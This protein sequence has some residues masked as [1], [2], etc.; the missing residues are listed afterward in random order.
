MKRDVVLEGLAYMARVVNQVSSISEAYYQGKT[1]EARDLL[2][3]LIE[4]LN[5]LEQMSVAFEMKKTPDQE[6]RIIRFLDQMNDGVASGDWVTIID[7]IEYELEQ[8]LD[9]YRNMFQQS[10]EVEPEAAL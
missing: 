10:L 6:N 5:W 4:G 7:S 3:Q 1:L 8:V 2:N 9:C